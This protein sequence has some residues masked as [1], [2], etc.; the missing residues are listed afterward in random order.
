MTMAFGEGARKPLLMGFSGINGTLASHK[1]IGLGM[2]RKWL[3]SMDQMLKK[4]V[5]VVWVLLMYF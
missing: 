2:Y 1:L 3:K 5:I 4:Q